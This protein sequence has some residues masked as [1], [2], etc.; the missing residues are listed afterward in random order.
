MPSAINFS[1]MRNKAIITRRKNS[2]SATSLHDAHAEKRCGDRRQD[3]QHGE[4]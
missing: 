3:E 2:S 4:T 1:E